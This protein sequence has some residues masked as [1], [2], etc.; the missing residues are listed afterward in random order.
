M[1]PLNERILTAL[2][3]DANEVMSVRIVLDRDSGPIAEYTV[4]HT[5]LSG[6][7][8][9]RGS[10]LQVTDEMLAAMAPA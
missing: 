9:S 3:L 2:G 6:R 8:S 1:N 5:D 10:T 7:V 4:R